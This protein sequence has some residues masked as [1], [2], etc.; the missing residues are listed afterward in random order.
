[1]QI[2]CI[3]LGKEYQQACVWMRGGRLSLHIYGMERWPGVGAISFLNEMREA[4]VFFVVLPR[5]CGHST[6]ALRSSNATNRVGTTSWCACVHTSTSALCGRDDT[7]AAK[8]LQ[9]GWNGLPICVL[10]PSTGNVPQESLVGN[11]ARLAASCKKGRKLAD[12]S[13]PHQVT[14]D[15][16]LALKELSFRMPPL[17][18]TQVATV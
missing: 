1:M 7:M 11:A 18:S 8:K 6:C 17:S 13:M 4:F 15:T 5:R 3:L 9:A 2:D 12:K 14:P 16:Q 10:V